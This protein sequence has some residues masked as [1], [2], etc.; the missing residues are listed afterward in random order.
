MQSKI[1]ALLSVEID[2]VLY[3]TYYMYIHTYIYN[4]RNV[5]LNTAISLERRLEYLFNELKASQEMYSKRFK[6][7]L[8]TAFLNNFI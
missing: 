2:L 8:L 7:I 1:I 4:I 5:F 3:H 6:I